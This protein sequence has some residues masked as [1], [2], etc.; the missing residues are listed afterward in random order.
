MKKPIMNHLKFIAPLLI[1]TMTFACSRESEPVAAVPVATTT[2][3]FEVQ[4]MHCDGCANA[5]A[6]KAGRVDGVVECDVSLEDGTAT[7]EAEPDSIGDV[8]AAI[9]SLG[10][11]VSPAAQ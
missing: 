2:V 10:Y 3:V 8:E 6:T 4:G 9:A 5:I 11:T 1:L 7:V